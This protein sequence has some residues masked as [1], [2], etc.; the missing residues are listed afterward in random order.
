MPISAEERHRVLNTAQLAYG[1]PTMG[2][3]VQ[4]KHIDVQ[5]QTV[6]L[7][8]DISN[9]MAILFTRRNMMINHEAELGTHFYVYTVYTGQNQIDELIQITRRSPG[10]F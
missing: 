8:E 2:E 10:S 5:K 6:A 1:K 9:F 7:L 3:D 4:Q